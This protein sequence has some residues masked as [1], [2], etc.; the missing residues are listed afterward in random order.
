M[1]VVARVRYVFADV[2]EEGGV[3]EQLT[4]VRS[5]PVEL[6]GRIEELERQHRDLPRMSLGPVATAAEAL[7]RLAADRARITRCELRVTA[8][9]GVEHDA[10]A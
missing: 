6:L 3:L 4:L 7:H 2:V 9:D 5:E 8:A 10:L 1:A